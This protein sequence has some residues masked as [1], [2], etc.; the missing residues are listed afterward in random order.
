[1]PGAVAD[2]TQRWT[3]VVRKDLFGLV[4]CAVLQPGERLL[5]IQNCSEGSLSA[6]R[7]KAYDSNLL[8]LI[9][10]S[11]VAFELWEWRK[12]KGP[13]TRKKVWRLRKQKLLPRGEFSDPTEWSAPLFTED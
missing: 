9:H 6:H 3:G 4:D 11:G 5:F 7:K 13:D 1:M 8:G 10:R 12:R 2:T